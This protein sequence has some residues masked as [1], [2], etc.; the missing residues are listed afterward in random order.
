LSNNKRSESFPHTKRRNGP[1]LLSLFS[2]WSLRFW[3]RES[4][5]AGSTLPS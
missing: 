3:E 2:N 1:L 4:A 5:P